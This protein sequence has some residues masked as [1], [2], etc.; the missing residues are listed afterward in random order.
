MN[1]AARLLNS[2]GKLYVRFGE[3]SEPGLA[4]LVRAAHRASFSV[5]SVSAAVTGCSFIFTKEV[6][7]DSEDAE[8]FHAMDEV[9]CQFRALDPGD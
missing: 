7:D 4:G 5:Y 2:T 3:F 8:V 9:G 6:R 1:G